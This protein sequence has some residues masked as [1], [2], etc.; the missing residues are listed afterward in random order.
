[1]KRATAGI[2]VTIV[3]GGCIGQP[4]PST[5]P[6][7]NL[8]GT[9]SAA[10]VASVVPLPSAV[11]T[12]TA[13]PTPHESIPPSASETTGSEVVTF[14][15]APPET[16]DWPTCTTFQLAMSGFEL[17]AGLGNVAA[18]FRLH[19]VSADGCVLAGY[20]GIQMISRTGRELPTTVRNAV[21]GDYMFPAVR[22][23]RVALGPGESASFELGYGDNPFGGGENLPPD[24]ACPQTRW[25]RI[26]LP[27]TH[28]FGTAEVAIAP[29]E[30]VVSVSPLFPGRDRLQFP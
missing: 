13:S 7:P 26:F 1:V 10:P 14:P 17:G 21:T 4:T 24:V 19:N 20:P 30:G 8:S 12:A 18:L 23:Q 28:Q 25:V 11:S 27:G 5:L 9:P 15:T 22:L 3:L 6:P 29:C 2:L 16:A